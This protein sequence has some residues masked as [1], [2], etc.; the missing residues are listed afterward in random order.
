MVRCCFQP[1]DIS[2]GSHKSKKNIFNVNWDTWQD[3]DTPFTWHVLEKLLHNEAGAH[4]LCVVE[5][6]WNQCVQTNSPGVKLVNDAFEANNSEESRAETGQPGQ[7]QDGKRQQGLPAGRLRQAAGKT[8]NCPA[9][10]APLCHRRAAASVPWIRRRG[11]QWGFVFVVGNR[12]M[13]RHILR[14]SRRGRKRNELS[15]ISQERSPLF[16]FL[17]PRSTSETTWATFPYAALHPLNA[18]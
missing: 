4:G 1:V 16:S 10:T 17:L 6:R 14:Q 13:L 18:D 15:F 3:Y 12:V 2:C 7:E 5:K 8:S 9:V 11:V